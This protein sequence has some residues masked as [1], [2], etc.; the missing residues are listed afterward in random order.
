MSNNI[1]LR[2]GREPL[3]LT[4]ITGHA[5]ARTLPVKNMLQTLDMRLQFSQ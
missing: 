5:H 2:G 3:S 4:I 1:I